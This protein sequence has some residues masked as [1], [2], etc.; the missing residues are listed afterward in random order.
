MEESKSPAEQ[1][2]STIEEEKSN[3]SESSLDE[4]DE[5]VKDVQIEIT[6]TDDKDGGNPSTVAVQEIEDD[7]MGKRVLH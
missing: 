6:S 2:S 3:E 4:R 7:Q 1:A 5:E